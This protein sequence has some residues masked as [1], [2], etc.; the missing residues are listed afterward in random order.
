MELQMWKIVSHGYHLSS[1]AKI[2]PGLKVTLVSPNK[3]KS[4]LQKD[5]TISK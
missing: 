3:V 2:S 4:E 5:Q 1:G